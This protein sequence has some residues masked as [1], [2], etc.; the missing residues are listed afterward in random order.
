MLKRQSVGRFFQIRRRRMT[1]I[2]IF[3]IIEIMTLVFHALGEFTGMTGMNAVI[4]GGGNQEYFRII[5][6]RV[7][8]MIR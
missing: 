8:I 5:A 3:V 4:L 2:D 6:L 7:E 1:A